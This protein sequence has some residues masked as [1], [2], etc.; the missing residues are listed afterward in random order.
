MSNLNGFTD[1]A[2]MT[3]DERTERELVPPK[4]CCCELSATIPT[5][6]AHVFIKTICQF[7]TPAYKA[8]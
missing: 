8:E 5:E 7:N 3:G 1:Q 6:S 4:C 2:D